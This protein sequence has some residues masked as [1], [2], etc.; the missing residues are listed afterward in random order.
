MLEG[1]ARSPEAAE[2]DKETAA[3]LEVWGE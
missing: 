3:A 1:S 2:I